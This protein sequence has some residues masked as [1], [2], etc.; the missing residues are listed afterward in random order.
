MLDRAYL[1]EGMPTLL[2]WGAHDAMIPVEHAYLAADAM[3]GSR[4]EIFE[5]AGHFPHHSDPDRFVKVV[6]AFLDTSAPSC[7]E[8]EVWRERLRQGQPVRTVQR[9]GDTDGTLS[10]SVRSGT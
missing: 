9:T 6:R 1:A 5:N 3:T 8:P 7:F 4:L 2:L 10:G